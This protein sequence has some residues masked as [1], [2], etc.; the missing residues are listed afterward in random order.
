[1]CCSPSGYLMDE[2]NGECP[3]CGEPTVDG[4][5]YENCT[6]SRRECD[7]CGWSPCDDSC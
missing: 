7:V 2:I 4:D 3:N 6:Y 5:A 1:M